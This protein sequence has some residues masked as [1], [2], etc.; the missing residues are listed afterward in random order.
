[1][2]PAWLPKSPEAEF[3]MQRSIFSFTHPTAVIA[4]CV[5]AICAVI[6]ANLQAK[7][8]QVGRYS[9]Y[10]AKPTEAQAD[11]LASTLTI[12][13]PE[14]I[15][16]V[17]EAVRYLLQ[18]SGYRLADV[19]STAPD[20]LALF[21][22]PLPAVHRSLGPMTLKDA[23]GTLAGPAFHLV[24]DPVHRLVSFERCTSVPFAAYEAATTLELEVVRDEN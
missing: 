9:L 7:E 23:L 13:F 1:M 20:T 11:L 19:E 18:R 4:I 6:S 5:A 17:G 2:M 12:R 8:I 22:L 3:I 15:Q 14:R 16:T 10:S 21:A 24:Q